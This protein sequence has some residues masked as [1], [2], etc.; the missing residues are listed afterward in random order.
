M[1]QSTFS[2]P[3]GVYAASLFLALSG[4][5][6]AS[7]LASDSS[8]LLHADTS[9][10]AYGLHFYD[11]AWKATLEANWLVDGGYLPA[12]FTDGTIIL[13]SVGVRY[14][15]NSSYT[16][17]GNS[18]KKP[19][20]IKF[21][22]FRTQTYYGT[23]V[24]N[25]SNVIGDPSFLREKISYDVASR[26]LPAPRS[27]FATLSVDAQL[28]GLYTQVEDLDKTMLKRWYASA[29]GNLYKAGD[30]GASLAWLG[31]TGSLYSESG[32]YEL[33]TNE[34]AN[35]WTG[36]VNFVDF[37]NNASDSV[38]CADHP[39]FLDADNVTKELAFNMVFSNFDSYTG[40]GR[41]YYL[42]Q[43][44][45]GPMHILPWDLNLSFG[46]Y[47]NGW[48]VI[49]QD[50]LTVGNLADRPLNRRVLGCEPLRYRYL[51]WVRTMIQGAAST[52]SVNAHVARLAPIIRPYVSA[53]SNKFYSTAAFETNLTANFRNSSGVILGLEY[54]SKAR[55]AKLLAQVE[56]YLPAGYVGVKPAAARAV[57]VKV[58]RQG[59][60]FVL[61]AT[62]EPVRIEL[63]RTN[64][65]KLG[66]M[67]L[68]AGEA[69]SL[70]SL[71][72]GMVLLRAHLPTSTQ[73]QVL[74][75]L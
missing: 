68:Q 38:F 42:Y 61:R 41:N 33:K 60:A 2:C 71:P 20:K 12:R 63:L 40:S 25:F 50:L 26:Y 36:F 67:R 22:A 72:R 46:A 16:L 56:A 43:T 74:N 62:S 48:D 52:D 24:L 59:T 35:D 7:S 19:F 39:R 70:N 75:N 37:L 64:G 73:T 13:D 9:V 65:T 8:D 34:T 51:D 53:D 4:G 27:S 5:V 6:W 57:A 31:A 69:T 32:T 3:H 14:K 45:T 28:V 55:N 54:F 10:H 11:T 44:S 47:S 49:N 21:N 15:G 29:T 23:K 17:A 30:D 1:H 66:E 58:S 18:P